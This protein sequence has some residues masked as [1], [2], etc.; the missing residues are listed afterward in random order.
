MNTTIKACPITVRSSWSAPA[1]ALAA[2]RAALCFDCCA[3][4]SAPPSQPNQEGGA[5]ILRRVPRSVARA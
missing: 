1:S 5:Q 2:G 3:T 4:F